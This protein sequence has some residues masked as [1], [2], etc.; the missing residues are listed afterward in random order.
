[1]RTSSLTSN[2]KKFGLKG[3]PVG[4]VLECSIHLWCEFL[5]GGPKALD[6][7]TKSK[8]Q[9]DASKINHRK[10]PIQLFT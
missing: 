10:G 6:L 8:P 1:M 4:V 7:I 5:I 2:G 9:I 3:V